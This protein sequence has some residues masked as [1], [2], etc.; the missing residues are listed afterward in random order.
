[1]SSS[2]GIVSQPVLG[3]VADV[4]GYPASFLLSGAISAL[5]LPFLARARRIEPPRPDEGVSARDDEIPVRS[6]AA[7]RVEYPA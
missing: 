7:G 2:G 1:M 3:R 5:A 4:W 6:P